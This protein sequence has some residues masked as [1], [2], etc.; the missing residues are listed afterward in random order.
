MS[1]SLTSDEMVV[2]NINK[3]LN[4]LRMYTEEF[5]LFEE[6]INLKNQIKELNNEN[7]ILKKT[8]NDL[9]DKVSLLTDELSNFKKVSIIHSIN[10]ELSEKDNYIKILEEQLA[11]YRSVPEKE[12]SIPIIPPKKDKPLDPPEGYEYIEYNEDKFLKN[13]E[14]NKVYSIYENQPD[15]L[16]AIIKKSGKIKFY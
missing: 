2:D 16:V 14:D 1:S 7:K 4:Q 15:I 5:N 12:K 11:K 8:N 9:N 10:K 3:S 13:L 6:Y